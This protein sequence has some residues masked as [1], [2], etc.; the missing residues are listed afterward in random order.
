MK[1]SRIYL[2]ALILLFIIHGAILTACREVVYYPSN[3][4]IISRSIDVQLKDS[5]L[6]YGLVCYAPD[7]KNVI[8]DATV[9]VEE[10]NIKT[11]SNDSGQFSLKLLPGKHTIRCFMEDPSEEFSVLLKDQIIH[12]NEKVE[13]RFLV[14]SRSE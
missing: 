12:S 8:P 6:I 3:S 14:G 5:A 9:W 7:S 13:V 4:L 2:L 11:L 1:T 10:M